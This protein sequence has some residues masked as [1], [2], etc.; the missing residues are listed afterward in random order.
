M[1]SSLRLINNLQQER[2]T[3]SQRELQE[4]KKKLEELR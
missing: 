3:A 4:A 1:F 2:V